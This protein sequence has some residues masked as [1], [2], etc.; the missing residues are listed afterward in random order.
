MLLQ[1]SIRNI[2]IASWGAIA[3]KARKAMNNME[4]RTDN[5][6]RYN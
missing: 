3:I 5:I 2:W 1:D 4:A 6:E